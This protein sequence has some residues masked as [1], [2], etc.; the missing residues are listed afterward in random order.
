[1]FSV[2]LALFI[3]ERGTD[4]PLQRRLEE[5]RIEAWAPLIRD[6]GRMKE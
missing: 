2:A 5:S 1:M 4:L 3:L 6:S